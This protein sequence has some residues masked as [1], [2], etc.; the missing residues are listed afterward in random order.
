MTKK[1]FNRVWK[2]IPE[3]YMWKNMET[4]EVVSV[5]GSRDQAWYVVK[6]TKPVP[7][8]G[9]FGAVSTDIISPYYLLP[10]RPVGQ[11]GEQSRA[12]VRETEVWQNG[13]FAD[14]LNSAFDYMR[15]YNDR[16]S[17]RRIQ[18]REDTLW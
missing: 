9:G 5:N 7:K 15:H 17:V 12:R 1:E 4:M 3:Q 2:Q 10:S 6:R 18:K 8:E 14:A 16:K 11:M 13:T